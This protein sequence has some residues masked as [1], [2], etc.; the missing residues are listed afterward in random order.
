MGAVG[1]V[2]AMREVQVVLVEVTVLQ[3]VVVMVVVMIVII[4]VVLVV[5]AV[6]EDMVV[7]DIRSIKKRN[8]RHGSAPIKLMCRTRQHE[9]VPQRLNKDYQALRA[10]KNFCKYS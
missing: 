3:L 2:V 5:V 8:G 9:K 10:L 6:V 1:V 4:G 7:L